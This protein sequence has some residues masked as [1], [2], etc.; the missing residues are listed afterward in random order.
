M[1]VSLHV[2]PANSEQ[3]KAWDG[4]EGAFWAANPER[5]DR[6]VLAYHQPFM[7]AAAIQLADRVLDVGCGNGQ[8][9]RDAARMASAGSALGVDLS[10]RMLDNAL[11]QAA[12]EGLSNVRFEQADAQVY[13]FPEDAFDVAI[14]RMGV[15]FF[16]DPVAGLSNVGRALR[17]GGRL[18]L[19]T[20]QPVARAWTNGKGAFDQPGA[21]D[22]AAFM[23]TL[24]GEGGGWRM[25]RGSSPGAL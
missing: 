17:R 13:P 21:N 14:S 2:D 19:L 10:S 6:A 8:T 7:R 3:L 23:N 11:R 1:A 5:F 18:A 16:G 20:W 9:T 22:H 15:I 12:A 25:T 24:A 4:D